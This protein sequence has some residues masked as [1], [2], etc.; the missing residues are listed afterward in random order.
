M[1]HNFD[2]ENW[3]KTV[4]RGNNNDLLLIVLLS[5]FF[6][7]LVASA[8]V[9]YDYYTTGEVPQGLQSLQGQ[10]ETASTASPTPT[11]SEAVVEV[12]PEYEAATADMT[13]E[14]KED[15]DAFLTFME[16]YEAA[17]L[18]DPITQTIYQEPTVTLDTLVFVL[19]FDNQPLVTDSDTW[20]DFFYGDGYYDTGS[21]RQ[22]FREVS[23]GRIAIQPAKET[24]GTK[25]DGIIR[26][27]MNQKHPEFTGWYYR[28]ASENSRMFDEIYSFI[29]S[30]LSKGNQYVNYAKYDKNGDGDVKSDELNIIM[31]FAGY[32]DAY[33]GGSVANTTY[34][35]QIRFS[36]RSI[37]LDDVDMYQSIF[38]AEL[39]PVIDKKVPVSTKG[40]ICHEIGHALGL[41]DLYDTDY[42]SEGLAFHSL[43]AGGNYNFYGGEMGSLPPPLMAWSL[44][45]LGAADPEEVTVGGLY[46]LWQRSSENY[47]IIKIPTLN[48]YYLV[49]NVDFEGY[50]Q[51]LGLYVKEP[52]IAIWYIDNEVMNSRYATHMLA[53]NDDEFRP[54][55]RLVEP[56]G[57]SDLL[58]DE[59]D[60]H[61]VYDHYFRL[62][63]DSRYTGAHGVIIDVLDDPG[64]VMR[65]QIKIVN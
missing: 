3:H 19:S 48:G 23:H 41:P 59:F 27:K 65:I 63:G 62:S 28:Y 7:L 42:S 17:E 46:Y 20:A 40:T 4:K 49:E 60:Y 14:E 1:A 54:G 25:N 9:Y 22:Y 52:G 15:Y 57:K 8:F 34:S 55:V 33:L 24:Q 39:S 61:Q 44:T 32:E 38:T 13:E 50:G 56:N 31:I 36:T 30:V 2:E 64:E 10:P 21:V 47:N 12:D 45:E 26:L 43:M 29:K 53:V 35:A 5:V 18:T 16:R 37:N 51:G 11:P 6:V 58:H